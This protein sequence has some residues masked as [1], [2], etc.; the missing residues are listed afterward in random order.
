MAAQ[1][2]LSLDPEVYRQVQRTADDENDRRGLVTR[3]E[4]VHIKNMVPTLIQDGLA[5]RKHEIYIPKDKEKEL[6]K[7]DR[8][9]R[10]YAKA[11]VAMSE[12]KEEQDKL[13]DKST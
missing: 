11:Q 5:F 13:I 3:K 7:S 9:S 6:M 1:M 10:L 8:Y 2:Q 12:L 4:K